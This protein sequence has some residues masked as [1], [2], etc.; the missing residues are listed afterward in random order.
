METLTAIVH[1][2]PDYIS[3][4]RKSF[5]DS[6]ALASGNR[7]LSYE[8][9]DRRADQ[10]AGYL[11]QL[12]VECGSTVAI[13]MERSFNWI[14]A[15]LGI[16]RAGAAYVP[17]DFGWPDSR[18][19]FA[20]ADSGATFLVARS[21]LL[22]RLQCKAHGIDPCRDAP[23]IAASPQAVFRPVE[24]ERLAYVIYTS[25]STGVPKGVE[26]THGNLAHLIR[27][28]RYT[29]RVTRQDRASHLLGLGFDAAVLETWAHLCA[30]ATICL[31]DDAVRASPE[32]IQQW[33]IRERLTISIVPA[34][35]GARLMEMAWPLT[36][37]LRLLITGGDVLHHG[38]TT[39]LP[40]DVVNNYGPAE[41]TVVSTW[42]LLKP[43]KEET[44]PIGR[45]IAGAS[46]YLLDEQ[47]EPVADGTVGEIYIGGSIVGRGYR[48]LP[49]LTARNFLVDPFS[50]AAGARM[51][52]TGDR[53]KRGTNGEIEFCGRLDRQT[54]IRGQ[55]VELDE[56]AS[57]LSQYPGVNF[58]TAV[59]KAAKGGARYLV[60][61]ILLKDSACAP[62]TQELQ[63]YLRRVLPDYM[64]PS[65]FVRLHTL[66]LSPNGKLDL[67][68][69]PQPT[70]S[71]LLARVS[72]RAPATPM[73]DKLLA[74]AREL[75]ENDKLQVGDNFFLAG[76]HSLLG[77]QLLTHL[78]SAFGVDLTVQQLFESPTV[79]G[80]A[81]LIQTRLAEERL[82]A[83]WTEL[84]GTK[85]VGPK[86]NF[87]NSGGNA[88]LVVRLQ[89][90]IF[91][92]FGRDIAIADLVKSS[93][94][95]EQ[96]QLIRGQLIDVLVLP[97][98]VLALR[99]YGARNSIFW[100]HY[101]GANL[102][103]A[104]GENQPFL[105]VKL[106][107]EDVSSLGETPTLQSIAGKLLRKI[108]AT[109]S[110]GPYTIGGMCLGGVVAYEIAYQLQAEGHHVSLLVLVDPPNPS[111]FK[112][113][114]PMTPKLSQ[115]RYLVT[116]VAR[117]GL[118]TS[119]VKLREH[120][121][122][123][124]VRLLDLESSKT[125]MRVIQRMIEAAAFQYRPPKYD[126]AVLL[127]LASDRPPHVDFLPG[128]QAVVPHDLHIQYVNGHHNE[129]MNQQQQV[130]SVAHAIASTLMSIT[131]KR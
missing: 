21:A 53:G 99:H 74:L 57:V 40:F 95:R 122:E 86:T 75:L 108:L 97:P 22:D 68:M 128:W 117:L 109:Q 32:L 54:K 36:T 98:G 26:I 120:L 52:R 28:H 60:G 123:R 116:R 115:P 124:F 3:E 80:L 119:L 18:L 11:V 62:T 43:G 9:F 88:E 46:V 29:F 55:R 126:G 102:A 77:M 89:Q 61:Y 93:S 106:T 25:G 34:V 129:I 35:L 94:I 48:N 24:P 110:K 65:S 107:K 105:S 111:Y 101:L 92:E 1:T 27:W 118:R 104:M 13:C 69:L 42:A 16:M 14:V 81:S 17:L 38:P 64:V 45:P 90:R 71:N 96:A 76:G 39:Q 91:A 23:A 73:E 66:P 31:A 51:Y 70:D 19:R 4:L 113:L 20:I 78:K 112:S 127:L 125:E 79:E 82:I 85:P 59:A 103:R 130:R 47:C 87:F 15:A 58:A 30:G 67:T 63:S 10:F 50:Q 6:I 5:P 121:H 8:E 100:V 37:A 41:C 83:I 84:L 7:Q 33:M 49:E 72:A 12:G 114:Y 2:A 44:P 56:I 131:T